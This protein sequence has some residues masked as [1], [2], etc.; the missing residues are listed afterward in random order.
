VASP[1]CFARL[2]MYGADELP[3]MLPYSLFSITITNTC[4]KFGTVDV[5]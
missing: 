2:L 3:M 1:Y 4:A 5:P